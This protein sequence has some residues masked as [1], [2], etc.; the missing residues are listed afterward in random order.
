MHKIKVFEVQPRDVTPYLEARG[1][2][3]TKALKTGQAPKREENY[4]CDYCEFSDIC[5]GHKPPT[6][7]PNK[8][9]DQN[10]KSTI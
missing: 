9:Q 1:T 5:H 2:I 10:K 6:Y 7:T 4:F 3:L 8:K